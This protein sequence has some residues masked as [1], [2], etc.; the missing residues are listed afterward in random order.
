MAS[1]ENLKNAVRMKEQGK[2][3]FQILSLLSYYLFFPVFGAMSIKKKY[4]WL[5]FDDYKKVK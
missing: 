3:L 4:I 2:Y 5:T 1:H